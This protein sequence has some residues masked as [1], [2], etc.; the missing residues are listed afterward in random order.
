MSSRDNVTS[1]QPSTW[2][3]CRWMCTKMCLSMMRSG[4]LSKSKPK[5]ST[6]REH[7]HVTRGMHCGCVLVSAHRQNW[8]S[9]D[10]KWQSQAGGMLQRLFI[11]VPV[12]LPCEAQPTSVWISMSAQPTLS[13][14]LGPKKGQ[15]DC[16]FLATTWDVA[17]DWPQVKLAFLNSWLMHLCWLRNGPFSS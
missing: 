2:P 17:S 10:T 3:H 14:Y 12:S 13:N 9:L 8:R 6:H 15:V 4:Q 1:L 11:E 16:G 7:K 5:L